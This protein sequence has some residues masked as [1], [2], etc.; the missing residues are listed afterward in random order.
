MIKET[1]PAYSFSSLVEARN[2]LSKHTFQNIF[3]P[4][5][6]LQSDETGGL[7][8]QDQ[9]YKLTDLSVPALVKST[10]YPQKN[11]QLLSNERVSDD[12]NFIFSNSVEEKSVVVR[13]MDDM[14]YDV[15]LAK[16]LELPNDNVALIDRIL[17]DVEQLSTQT[18]HAISF[19]GGELRVQTRSRQAYLEPYPGDL[20]SVGL[21]IINRD[22]GRYLTSATYHIFRTSCSNSATGI[23]GSRFRVNRGE[24]SLGPIVKRI[25]KMLAD[26]ELVC[27]GYSELP[28]TPMTEFAYNVLRNSLQRSVGKRTT[29]TLL[30]HY[31]YV[32]EEIL[33]SGRKIKRVE[34]DPKAVQGR[35]EYDIFNELTADA[36]NYGTEERNLIQNACGQLVSH[37]VRVLKEM[38]EAAAEAGN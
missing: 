24:D 38:A 26:T 22:A 2:E 13:L 3:V 20:N 16:E 1:I 25:D 35:S 18:H 8:V 34:F 17:N 11:L 33:E 27:K 9:W 12:L 29:N 30:E 15:K 5:K 19:R 14:V 23:A 6:S 4:L 36:K 28:K 21:E 7:K 37:Y 32:D 10:G 31:T